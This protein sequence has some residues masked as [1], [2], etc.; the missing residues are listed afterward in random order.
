MSHWNPQTGELFEL[1]RGKQR[2]ATA[3]RFEQRLWR[4]PQ[5]V[6]IPCQESDG[7]F[8]LANQFVAQLRPGRGRHELAMALQGPKPFRA[9]RAAL[10]R[11]PGLKR[12]WL[13]VVEQEATLRLTEFCLSQAW[14]LEDAR[15]DAA[16]ERWLDATDE[17]AAHADAFDGGARRP[18]DA[19]SPQPAMAAA[20][21]P[22]KRTVASLSI[23][24]D[25]RTSVHGEADG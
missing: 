5:W 10:E 3:E 11:H 15:F 22:A 18:V 13:A 23:G 19:Q 25:R 14:R 12:R 9:L 1:P 24:G 17:D 16:V 20:I 6:E 8:Q 2:T 4:D 21:G 7:G